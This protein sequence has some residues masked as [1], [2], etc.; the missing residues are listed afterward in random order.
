MTLQLY[1]ADQVD[2]LTLQVLDVACVLRKISQRI[3]DD[4]EVEFALHDKKAQEWISRLTDWARKSDAELE[5]AIMRRRGAR[6]AM[7]AVAGERAGAS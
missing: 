1:D 2:R 3:R 7:R 4:V 5:M 6:R